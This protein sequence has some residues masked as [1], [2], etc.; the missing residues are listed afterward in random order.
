[1]PLSKLSPRDLESMEAEMAM[2]LADLSLPMGKRIELER[3]RDAIRM[4]IRVPQ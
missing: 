2:T 1:M 4:K 3:R